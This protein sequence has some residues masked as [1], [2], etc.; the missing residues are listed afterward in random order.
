MSGASTLS[1]HRPKAHAAFGSHQNSH[2]HSAPFRR[3]HSRSRQEVQAVSSHKP[4]GLAFISADKLLNGRPHKKKTAIGSL[5]KGRKGR[6]AGQ[7]PYPTPARQRQP[8]RDESPW[9]AS[10][11]SILIGHMKP[12]HGI[13]AGHIA[14]QHSRIVADIAEANPFRPVTA[15]I[16]PDLAPAKRA[17]PI[18]K[19]H[20]GLAH[21]P[22]RTSSMAT[23]ICASRGSTDEPK[24]RARCPFRLNSSLWKFQRGSALGFC[25]IAHW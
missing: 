19:N 20:N 16:K 13:R 4:H 17:G 7:P 25:A 11:V 6:N 14:W 3:F 10:C 8:K 22:A 23:V 9:A 21:A 15:L 12:C 2:D 18:I 1:R 24:V 5:Q